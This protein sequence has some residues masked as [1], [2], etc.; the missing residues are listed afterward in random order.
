MAEYLALPTVSAEGNALKRDADYFFLVL[1]VVLCANY[2]GENN[3]SRFLKTYSFGQSLLKCLIK[4]GKSPKHA[5]HI[6]TVH[7][8]PG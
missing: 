1:A 8:R 3:F 2:T 6:K 4:Q 5:S 7:K